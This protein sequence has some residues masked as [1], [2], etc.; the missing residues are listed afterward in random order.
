[1]KAMKH[2]MKIVFTMSVILSGL[3]S[4]AITGCS[5]S[6]SS[7]TVATIEGM[8]PGEYRDKAQKELQKNAS[9]SGRKARRHQ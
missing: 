4:V 2:M 3:S 7:Q 5:D 1:M 6:T 9:K 8:S